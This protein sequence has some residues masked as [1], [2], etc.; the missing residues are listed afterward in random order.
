MLTHL[1]G[2][3]QLCMIPTG[4]PLHKT[5]T[6]AALEA[7]MHVL[8]EKPAAG[9]S[10]DVKAMQIAAEKANRIVAVGYQHLYTSS[11]TTIKKLIL[12]DKIGK[13]ESIKCLVMWPRNHKY[14]QRNNWA[15]KLSIDNVAIN[16]S[17]FNN[18]VAHELM[19]MLFQAG[20]S[21]YKAAT[22]ISVEAELFRANDI[23]SADTAYIRIETEEKIPIYFYPTHACE[24]LFGPE[25]HIKGTK[26]NII[27]THKEAS[28]F[29]DNEEAIVLSTNDI[30]HK[31]NALLTSVLD[32]I[33]G[34]DS[35]YCDLELASQQTFVVSEI[36][37]TCKIKQ[38]KGKTLINDKGISSTIIPGIEAIMQK[39]FNTEKSLSESGL[40]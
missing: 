2:E 14:Y 13:I 23:E 40:K 29:P 19:M 18:A 15:G 33:H 31:R 21:Q 28:V 30:E 39:A 22:P 4:T 6:I 35:F 26:G 17:P 25:I 12:E 5:M 11:T 36:S 7:G 8:V 1:K 32:A 10:D 16:D 38:L 3:A 9:C 27:I 20:P 37:R 34:K 24:E